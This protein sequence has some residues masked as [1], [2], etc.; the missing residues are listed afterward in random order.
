ME[1]SGYGSKGLGPKTPF[2]RDVYNWRFVLAMAGCAAFWLVVA[3][4]ALLVLQ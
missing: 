3:A 4:R 2:T 1:P